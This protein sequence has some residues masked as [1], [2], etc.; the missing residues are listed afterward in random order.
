MV[1]FSC[2][3]DR[4][5][6]AE[7]LGS[8]LLTGAQRYCVGSLLEHFKEDVMLLDSSFLCT[9]TACA[10]LTPEEA[11]KLTSIC[12]EG[13]ADKD[14]EIFPEGAEAA[15]LYILAKGKVDLRYKLP[16]KPATKESTITNLIAGDTFG[17]SAMIPPHIYKLGAYCD[18][19]RTQFLIIEREEALRLFEAEPRIGY[20]FMTN[21]A[22][23]MS[24]RFHEIQED[25]AKRHGMELMCEW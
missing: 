25:L 12:K 19:D 11:D 3:A 20:I 21:L 16:G 17:W 14:D 13:K 22:Q 6:L 9:T 5:S 4:H 15:K 10:G 2:I 1:F 24:R 18:E 7:Y 23:V 8:I